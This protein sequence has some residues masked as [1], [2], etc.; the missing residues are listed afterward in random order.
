M[1]K[2]ENKGEQ[3][4]S[5]LQLEPKRLFLFTATIYFLC[6]ILL[7]FVNYQTNVNQTF[8][9]VSFAFIS[10]AFICLYISI[11]NE[12]MSL[13]LIHLVLVCTVISPL[14]ISSL[15]KVSSNVN[16]L[17]LDF[18]LILLLGLH[19][20][21]LTNRSYLLYNILGVFSLAFPIVFSVDYIEGPY[22]ITA[23]TQL[24]FA[25][26]FAFLI[27]VIHILIQK[28]LK[29]YS[30]KGN[31]LINK[32]EL[33]VQTF[34]VISS[35]NKNIKDTLNL[36]IS[37]V[38]PMLD[39]EECKIYLHQKDT[40]T[41][42]KAA[43]FSTFSPESKHSDPDSLMPGQG[44]VGS[45]A[46]SGK[47]EI[48]PDTSSDD[49]YIVGSKH[50]L[51]EICVP[52][53][54]EDRVLGMIDSEHSKIDFFNQTH[55]YI[56]NL[57]A[58]LLASRIVYLENINK[59]K[60]QESLEIE[61]KHLQELDQIKSQFISNV[62]H[63]LKTPLTLILGPA[64]NLKKG[65]SEN[66]KDDASIIYKNA[67]DLKKILDQLI[68]LN[69][70]NFIGQHIKVVETDIVSLIK[71]W[72]N[73]YKEWAEK[74]QIDL[75][76]NGPEYLE[77][78]FDETKLHSIVNNLVDN[79]IKY[80][81]SKGKVSIEY[82]LH[83]E[84]FQLIVDDSGI[85]IQDDQ[86]EK[87]F[88]R[89]YRIGS[90]DAK[91]T[92]IGLSIV[93]EYVEQMGGKIE[94]KPSKLGGTRFCINLN[95]QYLKGDVPSTSNSSKPGS[96][97]PKTP[98]K[99]Q[100]MIVEDHDDLRNFLVGALNKKYECIPAMNG[101]IG[102]ELAKKNAPDLIITDLMMPEMT[103]EEL[104]QNIRQ[105]D[106]LCHIPILVL[107]AK[108][109]TL[110]K[111]ELYKIG[112]DNYLQ[113]PFDMEELQTIVSNLLEQRKRLREAF[114]S[115]VFESNDMAMSVNEYLEDAF[116][117]DLVEVL[118]KQLGNS[119]FSIVDLCHEMKIGRNQLQKKVKSLTNM[120]PVEF[121][122][123]F[124]IKKAHQ[125]L[126]KGEFTVSEVAYKVGF[127]NLSYFT[128]MFKKQFG[129]LPSS[130]SSKYE[131]QA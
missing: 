91:G 97:I 45:V 102:F 23:I 119:N 37:E 2:A 85:G 67:K 17:T 125:L 94:V 115:E 7:L 73:K 46:L 79:A 22:T 90:A 53:I 129:V 38:I 126:K 32:I 108:S 19:S 10:L 110:D 70:S 84:I 24:S 5:L 41:F 50:G 62:S 33:I 87:I 52:I 82:M 51:S 101:K 60:S 123:S 63:D 15:V 47:T 69:S 118:E 75:S 78:S 31:P 96:A 35:K 105:T 18:I 103:G 107:S 27:L 61:A 3:K 116:M 56:I 6:Q 122:R 114:K 13:T 44:I 121:V 1:A 9:T 4:N 130:I 28:N 76:I 92:G 74:K 57:I 36:L 43:S 95:I 131:I 64:L 39:L 48:V 25:I 128:R 49:R 127:N 71:Q 12:K 40:N 66:P 104:A 88:E 77:L 112:A 113:K 59:I 55:K 100:V 120:T 80:T 29:Y 89:F 81:P 68:E 14:I 98:E 124:R 34:S 26:F 65:K 42:I 30:W 11:T 117:I 99:P 8:Y 20:N 72:T 16:L 109:R 83:D 86:K 111:I 93:R 58:T 106:H 54:Y 21:G